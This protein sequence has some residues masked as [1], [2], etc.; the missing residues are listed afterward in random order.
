[1]YVW[2]IV[3]LNL[4]NS[5][6]HNTSS[7]T[8]YS[9]SLPAHPQAAS[10]HGKTKSFCS[11]F[12]FHAVSTGGMASRL[13]LFP[14]INNTCHLWE[15]RKKVSQKKRAETE[16]LSDADESRFSL[17]NNKHAPIKPTQTLFTPQ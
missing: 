10:R 7:I 8:Q 9:A 1:M 4:N 12:H 14:S 2:S 15:K 6:S 11:F 3:K 13:S 17:W 16:P 5:Y